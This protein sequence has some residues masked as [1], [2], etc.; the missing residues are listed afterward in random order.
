MSA[1]LGAAGPMGAGVRRLPETHTAV[2]GALLAR[3]FLDDPVA[4][5]LM[6]GRARR[7]ALLP[8]LYTLSVRL[9]LRCGEVLTMERNLDALAA[10]LPPGAT[11]LP[12]DVSAIGGSQA[13]ELLGEAGVARLEEVSATFA[14]TRERLAPEPHW[15]LSIL[16]VDPAAQRSGWGT[17]LLRDL[18]RRATAARERIYLETTNP[19][20]VPF[21]ERHAF[22]V[23]EDAV[24]PGGLRFWAMAR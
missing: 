10:W 14:E 11:I 5:F 13:R 22:A 15:Y 16:A 2:A 3:A 4:V 9:A 1:P 24:T 21:Y 18:V 17:L 12:A 20:N 23:V 8:H 19:A 7:L 6:P